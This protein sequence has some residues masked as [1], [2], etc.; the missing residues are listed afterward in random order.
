MNAPTSVTVNRK[1]LTLNP[2]NI[3][4]Y[5]AG[6]RGSSLSI[7]GKNTAS[8]QMLNLTDVRNMVFNIEG[9][10]SPND[11]QRETRMLQ[12]S[13]ENGRAYGTVFYR[14]RVDEKMPFTKTA[15]TQLFQ[16]VD[17]IDMRN[18]R[19][20]W[21]VD[22]RGDKLA[23]AMYAHCSIN[24]TDTMLIR[25]IDRGGEK[26]IRSVHS[27]GHNNCYQPFSNLQLVDSLLEGAPEYA[28][29]PILGFTL[30]DDGLRIRLASPD[31]HDGLVT[32]QRLDKI[33][34][35]KPINTFTLRN[36]ETGQG[37]LGIDG[38]IWTLVCSNGMSQF[39]KEYCKSTP[40]RGQADRL[41]GWYSGAIEDVLTAQYG[42]MDRYDEALNTYV[43][44]IHAFTMMMFEEAAK[45]SR[46]APATNKGIIE[47]VRKNGL[48]DETTPQNNSVA[49][50]SQA[51]ALIAQQQD[52]EGERLLEEIAMDILYRGTAMA[53]P[54][55][56]VIVPVA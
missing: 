23:S 44:D 37:S 7:L 32:H 25:T 15:L 45:R 49:Q 41:V 55:G 30:N 56:R 2:R 46:H 8:N 4:K 19:S 42:V 1:S 33:E 20:H 27:A 31:I 50:V 38:G 10:Q 22:S 13:I 14:D 52:F 17:G 3:I 29:A 53:D 12:L 11:I 24:I 39:R 26:V 21:A 47:A 43:D 34:V 18:L 5:S 16:Y 48:Y 9:K 36:S 35:N 51:V 40:H 28:E 54:Q 6:V